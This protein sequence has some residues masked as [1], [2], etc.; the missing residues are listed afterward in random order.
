[1]KE[2]LG[3]IEFLHAVRNQMRLGELSRPPIRL[4]RFEIKADSAQCDCVYTLKETNL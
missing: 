3:T 2:I 4:D 1:M